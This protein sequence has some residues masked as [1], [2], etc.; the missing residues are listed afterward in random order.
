MISNSA[1]LVPEGKM[2]FADLTVRENLLIGGYHN[3]DRA[4]QILQQAVPAYRQRAAAFIRNARCP[5]Q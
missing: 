4:M 5:A 1:V 2:I 3:P